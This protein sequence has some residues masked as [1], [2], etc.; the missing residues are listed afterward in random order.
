[1][2]LAGMAAQLRRGAVSCLLIL[3]AFWCTARHLF[4]PGNYNQ[5]E[6]TEWL[7]HSKEV[8]GFAG[9]AQKPWRRPRTG[10]RW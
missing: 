5:L 9:E 6:G 7:R 2:G 10:P 8:T 1:M 3:T 4:M